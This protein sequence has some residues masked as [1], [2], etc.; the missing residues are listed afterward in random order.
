M[1]TV[2]LGVIT[3]EDKVLIGKKKPGPHPA[4][5]GGKWHVIGGVKEAGESEIDALKREVME[6]AH[7][8]VKVL[9]KLG[10]K[11]V[12]ASGKKAKV[13]TF[14]CEA[15]EWKAVADSDLVD[16]KWI[17]KQDFLDEICEESKRLLPLESVQEALSQTF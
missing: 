15:Q 4:G 7:L 1:K 8:K 11:I 2:V 16:V 6:E 12:T 10:E 13:I 9:K 3:K 17:P 14:L 5:L